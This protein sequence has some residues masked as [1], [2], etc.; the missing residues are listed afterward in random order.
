MLD[1]SRGR[2]NLDEAHD[3]K[4]LD[5]IH[6]RK[7]VLLRNR[8]PNLIE[9]LQGAGA[10]EIGVC[11]PAISEESR[12]GNIVYRTYKDYRDVGGNNANV[13]FLDRTSVVAAMS[14][15]FR[16]IGHV[17]YFLVPKN[18][19]CALVWPFLLRHVYRKKIAYMGSVSL[20]KSGKWLVLKNIN[21]KH[22]PGPNFRVSIEGGAK[23]IFLPLRGLRY[24]VLRW[25]SHLGDLRRLKDID[26]LVHN[27]DVGEFKKRITQRLGFFPVDIYTAFSAPGHAKNSVSYLPPIRAIEMLDRCV[28]G[29]FG[30]RHPLPH[31]ALLIF[32]YHLLFQKHVERIGPNGE[33]GENTWSSPV[34][35]AELRRLAQAAGAQPFSTIHEL[36]EF[37]RSAGW[38]PPRET[39]K[40]I[41]RVNPFVRKRYGQ[42]SAY[43]PGLSVFVVR[44]IA[45]KYDLVKQ[46]EQMVREQGFEILRAGYIPDELKTDVTAQ[47]RG[48]NW[49]TPTWREPEGQPIYF[50]IALDPNAIPVD[51]DKLPN[52]YQDVDNR[53]IL[54]KADIRD[55]MATVTG[56]PELNPVH[57]S[58]NSYEALE[59]VEILAPDLLGRCRQEISTEPVRPLA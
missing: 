36:E 56:I 12:T 27:S 48:G 35:F 7:I 51:A 47:F 29:E 5:I 18:I 2:A 49:S 26:F 13:V 41:A 33:L 39:I 22:T 17:Q 37:L 57:S 59:Y 58:D 23:E 9:Y 6:Q 1:I 8:D 10:A 28:V 50:M 15:K 52:R 11:H 54:F 42:R 32:A 45:Q 40:F 4:L 34:Y 3:G 43:R 31:D 16:Y 55:R 24:C 53:R 38:F 21:K 46:I 44:E 25:H 14:R 20:P 19:Y 30:E